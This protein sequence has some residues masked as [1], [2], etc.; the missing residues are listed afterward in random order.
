MEGE[1]VEQST[2]ANLIRNVKDFVTT[3]SPVFA[4]AAPTF[5][6]YSKYSPTPYE[7]GELT[8]SG[9]EDFV[10]VPST[11]PAFDVIDIDIDY[12]DYEYDYDE[13]ETTVVRTDGDFLNDAAEKEKKKKNPWGIGRKANLT[14][15]WKLIKVRGT[16]KKYWRLYDNAEFAEDP[17]T[18]P[19]LQEILVEP[20]QV[21]ADQAEVVDNIL[22]ADRNVTVATEPSHESGAGPESIIDTTT[23]FGPRPN[24]LFDT[25]P[26]NTTITATEP[27]TSGQS[28]STTTTRPKLPAPGVTAEANKHGIPGPSAS[29]NRNIVDIYVERY[30]PE[31]NYRGCTKR[32]YCTVSDQWAGLE[33]GSDYPKRPTSPD[34]VPFS[35]AGMAE[36]GKRKTVWNSDP[37]PAIHNI[38]NGWAEWKQYLSDTSHTG[39]IH[40]TKLTSRSRV[41]ATFTFSKSGRKTKSTHGSEQGDQPYADDIY[42]P[43]ANPSISGTVSICTTVCEPTNNDDK[44]PPNSNIRFTSTDADI[45]RKL[46]EIRRKHSSS[47]SSTRKIKSRHRHGQHPRS[48]GYR[49]R[50]RDRN[51]QFTK[52][53]RK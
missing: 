6:S 23:P 31:E 40:L 3:R 7:D 25:V 10:Y 15:S 9:D 53:S 52:A 20:N 28:T 2:I 26:R 51:E 38:I 30:R 42:D 21:N 36:S 48:P 1:P 37:R 29:S 14:H 27:S 18:A 49:T 32:R 11:T 43:P 5:P 45:K 44:Q 16:G 24:L 47:S 8:T 39:G 4:S 13:D 34:G 46:S 17:Q 33:F 35:P 22:H 12:P 50:A 19:I 41:S